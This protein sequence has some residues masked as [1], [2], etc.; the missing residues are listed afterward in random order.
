[1][2]KKYMK[3]AI[4]GA[5]PAGLA[6]ALQC[7]KYGVV[8]DL[9]ESGNDIGWSWPAVLPYLNLFEVPF[10]GDIREHLKN[11]YNLDLQ[12]LQRINK[13]VFKSPKELSVANGKL[14]YFYPRGKHE[15]SMENQMR[16][17]LQTSSILFNRKSDFKE[18]AK[19]YDYVVVA[20]G[21]EVAAKELGV[22]E[23]YGTMH[24]IAALVLGEFNSQTE[25]MYFNTEYAGQGYGRLTPFDNYHA[26]I[27][28]YGIGV[29]VFDM[30][31]RFYR[32]LKA[33]GLTGFQQKF[34]CI[35]PPF[36]IGKVNSFQVDNILLVG[37][38]AGLTERLF[39]SGGIAAL[40]SG[41]IAAE[42][43][44]KGKNYNKLVKPVQDHIENIS[45]LRKIFDKV[46]NFG[47]DKFVKIIGNPL[48]K[49]PLYNTTVNFLDYIGSVLKHV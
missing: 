36:S 17:L 37:R 39:G 42:A 5:G 28:L 12:P 4:I 48:V 8:A 35:S 33:E 27:T 2:Y 14:G 3:V 47:L 45:S 38:A 40:E 6:C 49:F 7:E 13:I 26:M 34:R 44:V 10:G 46:D 29:D 32:F 18:L 23:D 30:D 1:M 20:N 16:R 15:T 41:F 19:K 21:S 9:F 11:K 43:M 31:K 25:H 22:W 24:I